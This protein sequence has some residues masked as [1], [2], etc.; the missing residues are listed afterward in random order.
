MSIL[1]QNHRW[2]DLGRAPCR[3]PACDDGDGRE[4]QWH[5]RECSRIGGLDAV[6]EPFEELS[7][8]ERA[9]ETE[10][11]ARECQRGAAAEH[12]PCN[13]GGARAKR[14]AQTQLALPAADVVG[15]DAIEAD[16]S[17]GERRTRESCGEHHRKTLHRARILYIAIEDAD[18]RDREVLVDARDGAPCGSDELQGLAA[19]S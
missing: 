9:R 8:H 17:K 6:Q 4:N 11:D 19:R 14:R 15:H 2:V 3:E 1:S 18:V 16:A 10:P 13:A 5:E 7:R 12:E